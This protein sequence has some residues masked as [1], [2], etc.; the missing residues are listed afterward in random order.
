VAYA[1]ITA[2]QKHGGGGGGL[3]KQLEAKA[4]EL[5]AKGQ[6]LQKS[7]LNQAKTYWRMVVHM[8][9]TTSPSYGKAYGLLNSGGTAHK[10]EDEN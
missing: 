6:G 2:A 3:P 9:P 1:T 10:D 5:V 8:V 4:A 7:N